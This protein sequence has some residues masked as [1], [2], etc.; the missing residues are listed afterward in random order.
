[1]EPKWPT[2]YRKDDEE[3]DNSRLHDCEA[4]KHPEISHSSEDGHC[5]FG[6]IEGQPCKCRQYVPDADN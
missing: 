2:I 5:Y 3:D 4:C 1:M 6:T